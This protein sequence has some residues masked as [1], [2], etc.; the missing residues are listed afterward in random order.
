MALSGPG[1][2]WAVGDASRILRLTAGVWTPV[3]LSGAGG[4]TKQGAGLLDSNLPPEFT[5]PEPTD[6]A[7]LMPDEDPLEDGAE[8]ET[9]LDLLADAEEP[10][11]EA[12]EGDPPA[13]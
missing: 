7:A 10:D 5:V 12:Q 2:G 6:V 1:D 8:E 9:Q 11:K 13:G 3:A 4:I